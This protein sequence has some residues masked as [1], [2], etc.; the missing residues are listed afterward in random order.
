[1]N[2]PTEKHLEVET[3]QVEALNEGLKQ[4]NK[5]EFISHEEVKTKWLKKLDNTN[6]S[7]S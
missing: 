5:G 3:W 6:P 1:M 4:A 2:K 7:A